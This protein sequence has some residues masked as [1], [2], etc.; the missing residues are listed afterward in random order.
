MKCITLAKSLEAKNIEDVAESLETRPAKSFIERQVVD[1]ERGTAYS[2][3]LNNLQGVYSAQDF[4][5]LTETVK[6]KEATLGSDD[7][8]SFRRDDGFFSS[9]LEAYNNHWNLRSSP[10]DW[11][12]CVIR[13]IA[14]AIDKNAQ[15]PSVRH[16]FV[17]HKG[18]QTLQ[19]KVPSDNIYDIDYSMFFDDMSKQITDHVKMPEYVNAVT[20]DFSVTTSTQKIV[21]QITLM[22][23]VQEFFSYECMTSCG[24]PAVEMVGTEEDWGKLQSKLKVLK[25][26]L[27]PISNDIELTT[28]WWAQVKKVFKRLLATYKGKPDKG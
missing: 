23:S 15:K 22:S 19:V 10:D 25:K 27:K 1:V 20:A 2:K 7:T 13:R 5:R 4:D 14:L 9:V 21:S 12:Y 28:E 18:K 3:L 8:I 24:I 16:L 17:D 11:W 6:D 26:F